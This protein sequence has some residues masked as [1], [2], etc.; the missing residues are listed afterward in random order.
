[1][2]LFTGGVAQALPQGLSGTNEMSNLKTSFESRR[3]I[4]SQKTS[5]KPIKKSRQWILEKKERQRKQGK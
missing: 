2:V 5:G 3:N 1:L 4:N